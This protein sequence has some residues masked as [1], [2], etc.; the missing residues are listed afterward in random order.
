MN[1]LEGPNRWRHHFDDRHQLILWDN[2][3]LWPLLCQNRQV[4]NAFSDHWRRFG[5][6]K[7]LIDM[8]RA[9]DL[10]IRN[11]WV[12]AFESSLRHHNNK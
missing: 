4:L 3:L 10:R 5:V 1:R 11:A 6:R 2:H 12:R 8:R 9:E 7:L